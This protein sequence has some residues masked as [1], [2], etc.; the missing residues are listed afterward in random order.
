M[1]SC[2]NHL[3]QNSSKKLDKANILKF[4]LDMYTKSEFSVSYLLNEKSKL[5]DN[6]LV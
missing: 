6:L 1:Q 3:E 2:M 5:A 4:K